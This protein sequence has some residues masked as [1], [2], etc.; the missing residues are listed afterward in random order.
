MLVTVEDTG[1]GYDSEEELRK[2]MAGEDNEPHIGLSNVRIR[3]AEMCGG[4]LDIA[5]R[6]AGG[7]IV[8]LVIPLG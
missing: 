3:L 2:K 1:S 4:S 6:P 7:T 8:T 5:K